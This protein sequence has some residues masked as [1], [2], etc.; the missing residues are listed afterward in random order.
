MIFYFSG[1]GNSKHVAE[2]ISYYTDERLV[3]ISEDTMTNNEL[4]KI[5]GN[6]KIG[7]VFPIYW[8]SIPTIV[9]RFIDHLN[10]SGYKKQYVYAV[11]TYGGTAGFAMNRLTKI[12]NCKQLQLSGIFGVRMVDNYVVGYNVASIDRQKEILKS[13][14]AEIDK[15]APMIER[16]EC[17]QYIQRGMIAFVT[18]L[19]GYVYRKT[20]H[21]KKFFTT[22]A[23]NGCGECIREC[24]CNAIHMEN[25]KPRWTGDCTFCLKCIHGCKQTAIQC[26]RSTGKRDRYQY[27]EDFF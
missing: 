8:Y 6:E 26:G 3:Y 19:T 18:P 24:P 27:K 22:E 25:G 21:T 9:E 7:F 12:L 16:Q 14:E 2:K 1:T 11:A 10:I 5:E 17:I 20:T 13:S 4:Y 23:C 15:I